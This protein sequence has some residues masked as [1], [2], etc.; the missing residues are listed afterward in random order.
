[1]GSVNRSK[2]L[3]FYQTILEPFDQKIKQLNYENYHG[4]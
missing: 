2:I 3:Q 4:K 1:V